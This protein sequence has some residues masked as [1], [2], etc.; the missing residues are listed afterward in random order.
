MSAFSARL[1]LVLVM[2]IGLPSGVAGSLPQE[3]AN[4]DNPPSGLFFVKE[5]AP[6]YP[7]AARTAGITGDVEVMLSVRQD[8]SLVS[9]AAVSGPPLLRTAALT[10]ALQTTYGCR[11]CSEA[12]NSFLVVYTF[13]IGDDCLCGPPHDH[14][15]H[16]NNAQSA[17][18]VTEARYRVETTAL[19]TCTCD[20]AS[21]F[22][23]SRSL[24][25]LYLWR[26]GW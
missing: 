5:T 2:T 20:P 6:I 23:K 12:A 4:S 17:S 8:G 24:K 18:P 19:I 16:N 15:E 7:P 26:C 21:D 13:K 1:I 25:C 14:D 11:K 3:V 10:S 9:A 22:R